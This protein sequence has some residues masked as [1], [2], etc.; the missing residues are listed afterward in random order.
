MRWF[1]ALGAIAFLVSAAPAHADEAE[2]VALARQI[3]E[4]THTDSREMQFLDATLPFYMRAIDE[5]MHLTEGE[6]TLAPDM[7]RQEYRATIPLV[8]DH[9]AQTYARL[10][11]EEQLH[12]ILDFYESDAGKAF[13]AHQTELTQDS[14]TLQNVQ[15]DR[16][17]QEAARHLME[18][19]TQQSP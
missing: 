15:N 10:F 13:L 9:V 19:R 8:R 1:A 3:Y 4:I 11:T 5:A 16:V 2:R 17:V 12:Q 14:I 6:R 18:R 7:L